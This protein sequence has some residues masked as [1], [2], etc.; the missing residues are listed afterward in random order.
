MCI[1]IVL[2][3]YHNLNIDEYYRAKTRYYSQLL[4]S[5]PRRAALGVVQVCESADTSLVRCH[6]MTV[7]LNLSCAVLPDSAG[8]WEH[9]EGKQV[10][11][12]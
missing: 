12:M 4:L 8:E 5:V 1:Y 7:D 2:S 11:L 9:P 10:G 6:G 3:P